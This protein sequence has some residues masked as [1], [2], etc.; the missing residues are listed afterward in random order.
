M[1]HFYCVL[2]C[3]NPEL[4]DESASCNNEPGSLPFL[5]IEM[6]LVSWS[7]LLEVLQRFGFETRWHNWVSNL[8]ASSSKIL[9]NGSPGEEIKHCRGLRQGDYLSP[10]LFIL[11][12][13]PLQRMIRKAE[14][15]SI[16]IPVSNKMSRFRCSLYDDDVAIFVKP[17]KQD[18]DMLCQI[19]ISFARAYGLHTNIKKTEIFPIACEGVDVQDITQVLLGSIKTFPCPYLGLTLHTCKLRKVDFIPLIDKFGARLPGWK[20]K[21]FTSEN[22]E[23]LVKSVLTVLPIYHMIGTQTPKLVIKHIDRFCRAFL[24][25]RDDPENISAGNSLVNWSTVCMPKNLGGLGS[26]DL[27][28]F[29]RAIRL[30]FSWFSWK[31]ENKPWLGSELPCDNVDKSLFQ[32]ATEIVL[33]DGKK[34]VVLG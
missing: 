14:E 3:D 12:M 7:F 11:V 1:A 4:L 30:R 6:N 32:V 24:W 21:F 28:K 26:V 27:N 10:L 5:L 29:S 2:D 34:S 8:L 19:L 22:R 20:G 23:T 13:E 15:L 17:T 9:L 16:L 25:K 18:L 31:E 33:G